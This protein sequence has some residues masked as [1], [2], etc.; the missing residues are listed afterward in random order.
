M[1]ETDKANSEENLKYA[2]ANQ[3]GA[4]T[5]GG[6]MGSTLTEP[7]REMASRR[8]KAQLHRAQ[9]DRHRT[10]QLQELCYLLDKNPE[11]ARILDLIDAIG[12]DR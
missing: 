2:Y 10:E 5:I 1:N 11:I 12:N 3:Q 4:Q 6:G 7:T 9:R 8:F